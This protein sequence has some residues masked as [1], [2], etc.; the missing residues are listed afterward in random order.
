MPNEKR[1]QENCVSE[2][3]VTKEM[4]EAGMDAIGDLTAFSSHEEEMTAIDLT[5]SFCTEGSDRTRLGKE[6]GKCRRSGSVPNRW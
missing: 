3:E 1:Q 4:L 2:I 5:G 6:H